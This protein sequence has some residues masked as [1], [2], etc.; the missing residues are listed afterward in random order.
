MKYVIYT[1]FEKFWTAF[2]YMYHIN[3]KFCLSEDY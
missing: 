1:C 2:Y 3:L